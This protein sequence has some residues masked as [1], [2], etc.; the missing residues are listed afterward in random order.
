MAVPSFYG[1]ARAFYQHL[2][3]FPVFQPYPALCAQAGGNI[4]K[5]GIQEFFYFRLN[6]FLHQIGAHDAHPAVDVKAHP[7]RRD[8]PVT[9]PHRCYATDGKAVSPVNIRHRHGIAH[10]AGQKGN[11][12]Y[13]LQRLLFQDM[14]QHVFIRIN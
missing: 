1:P 8:H 11:I 12:G 4:R 6:I 7:A 3:Y 2:V 5:K 14:P 9:H 10:Y 13:L